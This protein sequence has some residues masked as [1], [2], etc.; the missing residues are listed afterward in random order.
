MTVPF[1]ERAFRLAESLSER[2]CTAG[3][4]NTLAARDGE[5]LGDNTDGVG[6]VRDLGCN[7]LFGFAGARVLL[8]GAGGAVRGVLRPLLDE[9]PGS[10][11]VANRTAAKARALAEAAA[12]FGPLAGRV[13]RIGLMGHSAT[14]RNVQTLLAA[15]KDCLP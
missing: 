14:K 15:L 13:W 8:L 12:G 6:L 4:V 3:A 1:K 5:I 9:K 2:A 10:L 7:H 11:L